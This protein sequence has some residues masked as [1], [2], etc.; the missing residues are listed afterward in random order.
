M[1]T[2]ILDFSRRFQIWEYTVGHSQLLL[3]STK[4]LE[5]ASRIDVLFKNVAEIHLPTI[6]DGLIVSEL[7]DTGASEMP[8]LVPERL[9][10]RTVF[11]A[12]TTNGTGYVIA[13]A[14]FWHEDDGC[15]LYTS[16]SPRD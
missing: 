14:T 4:T 11:V 15:L 5:T 7:T 3:R 1:A 13:G 6:L 9:K 12:R 16:P 2:T 10:T 8:L